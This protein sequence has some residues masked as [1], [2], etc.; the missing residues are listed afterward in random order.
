MFNR[1]L[2]ER[3]ASLE[4]QLGYLEDATRGSVHHSLQ[5]QLWQLR[6][7]LDRLLRHLGL[8]RVEIHTV[9]YHRKSQQIDQ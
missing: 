2:K 7:D 6:A 3:V 5:A 4:R 9:E 1:K 8:E